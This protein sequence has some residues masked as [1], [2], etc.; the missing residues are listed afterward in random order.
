MTDPKYRGK[1]YSRILMEAIMKEYEGKVDGIYL[2]AND[3]V[4]DFYPRFGFTKRDEY[5]YVKQIEIS[6]ERTVGNVSMESAEVEGDTLLLYAAWGA[7]F[8]QLKDYKFM[9]QAISH[10]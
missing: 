2:Y 9:L 7:A 10:A 3:S 8:E 1:G 5:Q 4:L 6:A